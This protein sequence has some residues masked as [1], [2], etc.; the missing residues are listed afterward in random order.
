MGEMRGAAM[1]YYA[2]LS[3]PPNLFMNLFSMLD[4]NGD[5][6][7]DFEDC[8]TL[9]YMIEGRGIWCCDGCGVMLW[10]INFVCVKCYKAGGTTY[11]LCCGCFHI[12]TSNTN[13]VFLDNFTL[14]RYKQPSPPS[15]TQVQL[16]V[17]NRFVS[18]LWFHFDD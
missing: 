10:G 13:T 5:G 1:A 12:E 3:I 9:Y 11:E 7:L 18:L 4:K 2:N 17:F 14:L 16:L 15:P 6:T 8:M